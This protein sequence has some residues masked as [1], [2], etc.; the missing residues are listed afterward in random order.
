[1]TY[2]D[3]YF[4]EKFYKVSDNF[5]II[6]GKNKYKVWFDSIN[7]FKDVDINIE[8]DLLGIK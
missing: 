6:K 1:M 4:N 2:I 5:I 8:N 3:F 7:N